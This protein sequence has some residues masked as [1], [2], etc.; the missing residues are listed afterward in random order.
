MDYNIKI[1]Q[2]GRIL[3]RDV[4][5]DLKLDY[6]KLVDKDQQFSVSF[7]FCHHLTWNRKLQDIIDPNYGQL[8]VFVLNTII[9]AAK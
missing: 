7:S 5:H 9:K 3:K 8:H 4:P 2:S 1:S 6:G